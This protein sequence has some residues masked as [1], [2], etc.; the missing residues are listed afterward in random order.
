MIAQLGKAGGAA[1]R[2]GHLLAEQTCTV[3]RAAGGRKE[4]D[5]GARVLKAM[6]TSAH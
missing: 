5:G 6:V 1:G 4:R 2:T 3:Q